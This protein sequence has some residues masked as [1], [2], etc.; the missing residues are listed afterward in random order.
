M[1]TNAV[2]LGLF[3]R[4]SKLVIGSVCLLAMSACARVTPLTE[5]I[6]VIDQMCCKAANEEMTEFGGCREDRRHCTDDEPIWIRGAV[7]CTEHRP[8]EC[9]GGRCC[10][11][12][13]RYGSADAIL[14]WEPPS[15]TQEPTTGEALEGMSHDPAVA[16][17]PEGAPS[18]SVS[19]APA[20]Q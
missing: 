4:A 7:T 13:R 6:P 14:T 20:P 2:P 5:P 18:E 12:R 11:Y 17:S 10:K 9:L 8:A 19:A 1:S 3:A 16:E 15:S